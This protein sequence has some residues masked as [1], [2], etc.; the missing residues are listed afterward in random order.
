M[1]KSGVML[2]LARPSGL[3]MTPDPAAGTRDPLVLTK[4]FAVEAV[5]SMA[6]ISQLL[7]TSPRPAALSPNTKVGPDMVDQVTQVHLLVKV[8]VVTGMTYVL[9]AAPEVNSSAMVAALPHMSLPCGQPT[10]ASSVLAF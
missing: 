1:V 9:V 6:W 2:P 5:Y 7:P 10:R 3:L 8:I 4:A